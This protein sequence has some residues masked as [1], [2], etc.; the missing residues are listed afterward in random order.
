MIESHWDGAQ[1]VGGIL[2][3]SHSDGLIAVNSYFA[4]TLGSVD[5][6][7]GISEFCILHVLIQS[8]QEPWK[9]FYLP[10]FIEALEGQQE[11]F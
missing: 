8:S 1:G 11:L 4:F 3:I 10:L 6:S 7:R 2:T 9:L 5:N